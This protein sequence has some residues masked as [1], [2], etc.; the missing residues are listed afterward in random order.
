MA[1]KSAGAFLLPSWPSFQ[2]PSFAFRTYN[3]VLAICDPLRG[4]IYGDP[5]WNLSVEARLNSH[6]RPQR[7]LL[8]FVNAWILMV[9]KVKPIVVTKTDERFVF[10]KN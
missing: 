2:G 1:Q 8:A 6:N 7:K 9:K 3:L 4:V 10:S 5:G